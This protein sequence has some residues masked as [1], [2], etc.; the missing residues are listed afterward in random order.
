MII[1]IQKPEIWMLLSWRLRIWLN[2]F[3]IRIFSSFFF[4][5]EPDSGSIVLEPPQLPS[6]GS[7]RGRRIVWTRRPGAWWS[8]PRARAPCGSSLKPSHR[9][10]CH[11]PYSQRLDDWMTVAEKLPWFVG[12]H[13]G[14]SWHYISSPPLFR[15]CFFRSGARL[16]VWEPRKGWRWLNADIRTFWWLWL[17]R[18]FELSFLLWNQ[19]LL[20][21]QWKSPI[22]QLFTEFFYG[23]CQLKSEISHGHGWFPEGN[24]HRQGLVKKRYRALVRGNY[25]LGS[26]GECKEP[27]RPV[28]A[29]AM[30]GLQ[31]W[32]VPMGT[33]MDGLWWRNPLNMDDCEGPSHW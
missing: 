12:F 29:V 32:M 13:H 8:W 21:W 31:K 28:R 22:N 6:R 17:Q 15:T 4:M 26:S 2:M 20:T 14:T 23:L 11:G 1:V 9:R 24:H 30:E 16:L 10:G 25:A 18:S 27:L 33:P 3:L 7:R 5:F 19:T